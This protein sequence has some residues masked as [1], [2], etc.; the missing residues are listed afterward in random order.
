MSDKEILD[1]ALKLQPVARA[2]LAQRL[3]SSIDSEAMRLGPADVDSDFA[4]ELERRITE[5]EAGA[6]EAVSLSDIKTRI[7]KQRRAR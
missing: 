6:V 3:W 2:E 5:V 1:A 7:A 4:R